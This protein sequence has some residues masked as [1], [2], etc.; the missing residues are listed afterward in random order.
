MALYI[1]EANGSLKK[2]HATKLS[3][4]LPPSSVNVDR[5]VSGFL[6]GPI[7]GRRSRKKHATL[8][9]FVEGEGFSVFSRSQ[10]V[11]GGVCFRSTP[12]PVTVTT[13]IIAFLVGNPYK[14][15]FATVTGWGV[16]PMYVFFSLGCMVGGLLGAW[17]SRSWC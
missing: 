4:F 2:H 15:S 11:G 9:R 5:W 1:R 10:L 14:P 12:H 3:V 7:R 6:C 17:F 8:G 13:R 16:D